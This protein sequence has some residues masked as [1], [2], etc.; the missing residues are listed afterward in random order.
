M[1]WEKVSEALALPIS[2]TNWLGQHPPV[3]RVL[4]ARRAVDSTSTNVDVVD[5]LS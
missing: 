3:M 1:T 4:F 2:V 5:V